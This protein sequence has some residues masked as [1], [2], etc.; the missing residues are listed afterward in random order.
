MPR[1]A[2]DP[3]MFEGFEKRVVETS[4]TTIN[5]VIGG[6]G[7]PLLLLHGYPQSHVMWH[8]VAPRLA[9]D[10]S[11]VVTDLR[12][13]GDSG[14]PPSGAGQG[15]APYS[16]RT[17]AQDQVEVMAALGHASFMI[18]GHDRG[19][20]V[21]HRMA[22]DHRQAVEKVAVLDIAPTHK[23]FGTADQHLARA[24]FHW[25]FLIQREP[26]PETL[27][28]A[29]AEYYLRTML[30]RLG[31]T[32]ADVFPAE[33]MAEYVR[34]FSDAEVIHASCEDYRA[35]AT[36]DLEHDEADMARKVSAPLLALWGE[37][38]VVARLYDVLAVWRERAETVSGKALPCGH[39]LPEE[40]PDHTC[41]ELAAFF[42]G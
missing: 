32:G 35:A 19:G 10:F 38:G 9:A 20:R 37:R 40:A 30:G 28:G 41:D 15:H 23:V 36:I 14:K 21:A 17:M 33:A 2:R 4:A 25:F 1:Q 29:D 16:K 7:P 24:Y 42:R 5:A 11:V 34:A 12:G 8:K 6:E 3:G 22:L 26:F 39:Y 31:A 27:I 13:Y 18:A